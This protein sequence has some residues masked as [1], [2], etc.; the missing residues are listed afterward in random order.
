MRFYIRQLLLTAFASVLIIGCSDK[1]IPPITAEKIVEPLRYFPIEDGNTWFYNNDEVVRKLEG[2]L[3]FDDIDC[4]RLTK[5][6]ETDEAW[7]LTE[8]RFAQHILAGTYWFD[9]PLEIPFSLEK[10]KPFRLVSKPHYLEGDTIEL[11]WLSATLTFKGYETREIGDIQVDSCI[12]IAYS[13][14]EFVVDQGDTIKGSTDNYSEY[15][16]RGI[17]LIDNGSLI[18]D[19]AIID[20]VKVPQ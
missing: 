15:Y 17:G 1:P 2:I 19:S 9:P 7:T 6:G 16:G 5:N 13:T 20:G 3:I 4:L 10:D 18:L 12:Q 8:D 14:Y 11:A